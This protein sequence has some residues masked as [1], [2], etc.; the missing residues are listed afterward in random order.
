MQLQDLIDLAMTVVLSSG[1]GAFLAKALLQKSIDSAFA[2]VLEEYKDKLTREMAAYNLILE[3]EMAYFREVDKQ[4]AELIPL[5]QDLRDAVAGSSFD[6]NDKKRLLRYLALVMEAKD[7]TLRYEPYVDEKV[8]HYYCDLVIWLQGKQERWGAI[9]KRVGS[10]EA[11]NQDD[12]EFAIS[13][14]DGA[15]R[16]IATVRTVQF[17][18]LEKLA[19]MDTR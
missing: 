9:F 8:W 7:T 11:S 18:Y 4:C 12:K 5:I 3:R 10:G 17:G 2:K 6:E 19:G 15:L 1:V 16:Q 13:A 14:C